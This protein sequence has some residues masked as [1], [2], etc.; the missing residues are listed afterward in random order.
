[1]PRDEYF[2][3]ILDD[4]ELADD[5]RK[6]VL[7]V[8]CASVDWPS[9][10][11][12]IA[13][14]RANVEN[15]HLREQLDEIQA[16]LTSGHG[17]RLFR[18]KTVYEQV[19]D[20]LFELGNACDDVDVENKRLREQLY[21]LAEVVEALAED[22]LSQDDCDCFEC[23]FTRRARTVLVRLVKEETAFQNEAKSA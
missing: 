12:E 9:D 5:E 6:E 19:Q 13:L 17:E 3:S 21:A 20:L 14:A 4:Y 15:T 1:M 16:L 23:R 2:E 18:G 11:A 8:L 7:D 22:G 10:E